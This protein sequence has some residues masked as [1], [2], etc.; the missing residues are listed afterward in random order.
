MVGAGAYGRPFPTRQLHAVW[1]RSGWCHPKRHVSMDPVKV[2][3]VPRRAVMH[4]LRVRG[5]SRRPLHIG[6]LRGRRA[7]RATA[8]ALPSGTCSR[9]ARR[10]Q[11]HP[12]S[13]N[14]RGTKPCRRRAGGDFHRRACT[15]IRRRTGARN[16]RGG[17]DGHHKVQQ[18]HESRGKIHK[19]NKYEIT[20]RDSSG[21]RRHVVEALA[22]PVMYDTFTPLWR[23]VAG[24][25][26]CIP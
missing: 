10:P 18:P 1:W 4:T 22:F 19:L 8:P 3:R 15:P 2:P 20:S 12:R 14:H 11:A 13:T 6:E 16:P 5:R 21:T 17:H 25:Q 7:R 9:G 24:T 26:D 23:I